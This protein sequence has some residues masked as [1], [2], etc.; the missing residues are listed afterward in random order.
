MNNNL[1]TQ[2]SQ[3]KSIVL[4]TEGLS[5]DKTKTEND[6]LVEDSKDVENKNLLKKKRGK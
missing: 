2:E 5:E 3:D 1:L 4:I 6:I